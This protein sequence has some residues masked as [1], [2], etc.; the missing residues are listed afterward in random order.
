[1]KPF[2]KPH[3][4][5]SFVL[6]FSLTGCEHQRS[7]TPQIEFLGRRQLPGGLTDV[8]GYVDAGTG[9]EYA[10]AGYGVFETGAQ[11]GVFIIDVSD[12]RNPVQVAQINSVPGFDVKVWKHYVYSVNGTR[13]ELGGI[14]DISDPANPVVVGSFPSSHNIFITEDGF[15]YLEV[16]GIRIYDL[17]PDPTDPTLLW[18]GGDEGHDATVI[19]NRLYDFHGRSGTNIY[20]VS[21]PAQPTLIGSIKAPSIRYSHSGWTSEDG[22]FLYICDEGARHPNADITVWDIGNLDNPELVAEFK[23]STAIVHNLYIKGDYAF[24]SYYTSGFCVFDVSDPTAMKLAEVF[25]TS[26]ES[27]ESFAGAFGVYPFASSGNIYVTDR[28]EG[29][30]VFSF[31][32][33]STS[34]IRIVA[35]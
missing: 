27:S 4:V 7:I 28:A 13:K 10:I 32:T 19:G 8:W 30:F 14:L 6:L 11:G 3:I 12:P 29:L 23:D 20:D 22:R 17:N 35:P 2:I 21:T 31:T 26:P 9:K 33:S 25:D 5:T 18:T 24:V 15:M 16:P 1:M 34:S